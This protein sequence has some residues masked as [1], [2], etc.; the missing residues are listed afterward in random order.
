M[1]KKS[2]TIGT[3]AKN[4]GVNVETIRFYQR[5]S[6]LVQP[7]KPVKGVRHYTERSY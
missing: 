1:M 7:V 4:A 2:F 3:L 6:L 5:R